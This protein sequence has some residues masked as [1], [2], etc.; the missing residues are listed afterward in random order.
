MKTN[1]VIGLG[2]ALM[3]FLIEVD[4]HKL[5]ELDLNKGEFHLVEKEKAQE[6]LRKIDEQQLKIETIPG[7]SAANTLKGVALLGGKSILC[8]KVGRDEHG[9][10]Y[11]QKMNGHGVNTRINKHDAVTG[12]A[13]TFI[14]PDTERTFSV[15]LGAALEL[16]KEDILED[17][18]AKSKILHLEGYQL[19][20]QTK[21][22]VLHAM[23]LA[24]K[25]QT[26][27]SI[28]LADPGV[29]R[30]NKELF[31]ELLNDIDIVFVNEK[32]ALEFTGLEEEQA[33]LELVKKVKMAVV[34]VGERGSIIC[35]SNGIT[36]IDVVKAEAIDT[37]G[38]GDSYAAGF[39]YGYCNDWELK[40]SGKLGSLLAAKV[41]EQKGVGMNDLD[42]EKLKSSIIGE[43]MIKIGIIGGSG[44]DN[45]DILQEAQDLDVDTEYGKPTSAL[46][47]GKINGV[48]VVLIARHGRKHEIP[49][50]QVN[51]RVNIQALKDSGCTHILATTACGSLKKEIGRGDFV[52][53]DQFIDFTRLRKLTFHEEFAPG[54]MV[55]TPMAEPFNEELRKVLINSC[56]SLG[57]KHHPQ[58]TVV[59]IEGPRFSTK[60]ES[61]M[62]ASWGA[63]VINMSI[64]PEAIL[65]NEIGI[66]YAAVAMATDYDC[67][68]DDVP[69][70]SW[71]EV[72]KV[73]AENVDK[74]VS[75]LTTAIPKVG[76]VEVENEEE[77]FNLKSCIRTVPNWPKPGIMF[78]DI[79]TLL[80]NP[81]AF[82]YAMEKF[83][84]EYQGKGIDKIAGIE[85]RGFIF[86]S[87]LAKEL[88]LPFVLI[89]KKGK[90]P[91]E[92]VS[93]EY[94][95]EYGTDKIEIH[96][97]SINSGDNVLI[98]DD[99]IATGG[100]ISA[101]CKLVEKLNGNVMGIA[102]VIDLPDLGGMKK[103]SNYNTFKLIEFE[104]E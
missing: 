4:D 47:V 60:A 15:H 37:T 93:Q 88:G 70:V 99:L 9:E 18:I 30:R 92:T 5:V 39:L 95:L 90:L 1:D 22:T 80:E 104:G 59:T 35:T 25:H 71:E 62:F 26:L 31:T 91:H 42:G 75:L 74:V 19:E 8:G 76:N 20:G 24:K 40:D 33:A 29:V 17:D 61:K 84:E 81:K 96:K 51:N 101:A 46:K 55:H 11:E 43:K 41:V 45:P 66:P 44:L 87:V 58:G 83:R 48:N 53:L 32:E 21:E 6:L 89:R 14:T 72:L 102:F 13:I 36:K 100:T 98:I 86:G 16:Y 7:G 94:E 50:T 69:P 85:S 3:D 77:S 34:K 78:R 65:A 97:T 79:T 54:K 73:F 49:P 23:N 27:I 38:A 63:D 57:L 28:D 56:V 67:L 12:H 68:F 103:L 82:S 2:N 52:I 64:A 10:M